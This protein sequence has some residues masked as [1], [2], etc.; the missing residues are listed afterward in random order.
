[1]KITAFSQKVYCQFLGSSFFRE[2]EDS[3]K[4]SQISYRS[5][6]NIKHLNHKSQPM[7]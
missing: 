6:E 5:F 3:E 1:M 7:S 4:I 2:K